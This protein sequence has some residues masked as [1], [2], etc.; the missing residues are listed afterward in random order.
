VLA[1]GAANSAIAMS[2]SVVA[3]APELI[4]GRLL[5]NAAVGLYT[6]AAGLALQL[7]MLLSGAASSV[8]YP[9]F[10]KV[11][12]RGEPLGPPYLR[13]VGAYTGVT[14]PALAG[15]AV[16]AEPLIHLVYGPRWTAAAPLLGWLAAAQIAFVAL[17]LHADLPVLL[18]KPAGLMRRLA[19]DTAAAVVL[20]ALAAPFGIGWVALS[21]FTH[22]V[23]W[24]ALYAGMLRALL[25]FEMRAL[26]AIWV[27]SGVAAAAAAAPAWLLLRL[28]GG[29]E[30][31]DFAMLC[32]AVLSGV[33]CWGLALVATGHPLRG[34]LAGLAGELR[35]GARRTSTR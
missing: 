26:L 28:S 34:E 9:A 35:Y 10:T 12:D 25:G 31:M 21:R 23:I 6:R 11:R 22:G 19:I 20:V 17:P 4:A 14:W 27:R 33:A 29:A 3:R 24:V 8:F 18:G 32:A 15:L 13:V 2:N 1:I 7:R 5:G 16:L 30:R